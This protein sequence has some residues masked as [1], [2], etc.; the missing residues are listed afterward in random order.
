MARKTRRPLTAYVGTSDDG[1]AVSSTREGVTC[2]SMNLAGRG[3]VRALCVDRLDPDRLYAGTGDDGVLVSSDRGDHWRECNAGLT[4][5]NVFSLAQHPHTGDLYVGTE[6]ANVFR[7]GDQGG[8]FARFP[9]LSALPDTRD[10]YFPRPP[11]VAHVRNIELRQDDPNELFC[12]IEDGWL[13]HSLDGGASWTQIREGVDCDAHAVTF[14]PDDRSIVYASTG[15]FGYRSVDGGVTFAPS[16]DGLDRGYM[17]KVVVHAADPTRLLVAAARN[18]PPAWRP[19]REGADTAVYRSEDQGV[20]WQR[21][22]RGLASNEPAGTWTIAADPS[23]PDV[24]LIGLFDGRLLLTTDFGDSFVE[25]AAVDG[26]VRSIC[27]A[28]DA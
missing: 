13:V 14:M 21:L 11:H 12:A 17:T 15:N 4:Y 25:L 22:T 9:T 23:D 19:G 3:A 24:V 20:T 6:P 27:V 7:S 26:P 2:R 10:W 1:F 18:P 16:S 28:V 5:K 8:T